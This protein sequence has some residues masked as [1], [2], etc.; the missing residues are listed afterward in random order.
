MAR[1]HLGGIDEG[2]VEDATTITC[3]S[4]V[5]HFASCEGCRS[6]ELHSAA[7]ALGPIV[8]DDVVIDNHVVG[9]MV[10]YA[11]AE[12][13][14]QLAVGH[15]DG[16]PETGKRADDT[17]LTY[18]RASR[19]GFASKAVAMVKKAMVDFHIVAIYS[20]TFG[21]LQTHGAIARTC[22]EMG[23]M[24]LRHCQSNANSHCILG[25]DLNPCGRNHIGT[26]I[27]TGGII[28]QGDLGERKG[29]LLHPER[30]ASS[31]ALEIMD[32]TA[33]TFLDLVIQRVGFVYGHVGCAA[34]KDEVL[35]P[36]RGGLGKLIRAIR[37]SVT[38]ILPKH[39]N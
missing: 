37:G 13:V 10:T 30:L 38:W 11:W 8:L 39:G 22:G 32:Q 16:R 34:I 18:G 35:V 19:G 3:C 7:L 29:A 14:L 4:I 36:M 26:P 12:V 20:R 9:L 2:A 25:H 33:L 23:E 24:A 5:A 6:P 1:V 31:I 15:P 21:S 17:I 27:V 28:L